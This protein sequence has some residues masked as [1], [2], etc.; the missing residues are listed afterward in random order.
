MENEDSPPESDEELTRRADDFIILLKDL[1]ARHESIL[2]VSHCEF[3]ANIT[4]VSL[5]NCQSTTLSV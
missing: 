4:G 1:Q 3:I 5:Q 2:I